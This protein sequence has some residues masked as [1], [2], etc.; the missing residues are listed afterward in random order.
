[1][2]YF[3]CY[4][5]HALNFKIT[6]QI[7]YTGFLNSYL[8]KQKLF[9]LHTIEFRVAM[10]LLWTIVVALILQ[11]C[12]CVPLESFY[13]FDQDEPTVSPIDGSANFILS[14]DFIF[15]NEARRILY[16]CTHTVMA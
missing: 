6:C 1:M 14:E 12:S 2:L 8:Y 11:C 3:M 13:P 10:M 4:L 5:H 15:Y 7:S 9:C 16:V